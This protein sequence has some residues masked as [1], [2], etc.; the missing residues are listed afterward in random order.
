M[1]VLPPLRLS[2][3]ATHNIMTEDFT[4]RPIPIGPLPL[5]SPHDSVLQ[6]SDS[7]RHSGRMVE[8]PIA[9]VC[10]KT[11]QTLM[12]D[13]S[14]ADLTA[15]PPPPSIQSP[16]APPAAAAQAPVPDIARP[17]PRPLFGRS[18]SVSALRS[19][20]KTLPTTPISPLAYQKIL[21]ETTEV[22]SFFSFGNSFFFFFFP[23]SLVCE[24]VSELHQM[25]LFAASCTAFLDAF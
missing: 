16:P 22:G 4:F 17:K 20:R 23:T 1:E 3:T 7:G 15:L 13:T 9:P 5:K 12:E 19:D 24:I 21:N 11:L 8:R 6:P 25:V 14:G 2:T 18:I 10:G